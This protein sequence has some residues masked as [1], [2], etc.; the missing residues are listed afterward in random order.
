[1]IF[2]DLHPTRIH[3]TDGVIKWN[4]IG[5]PYNYKKLLKS[6]TFSGHLNYSAPEILES[7][8]E[9]YLS[10]KADVWALG[11]C[12]Y[13]VATKRDP[14]NIKEPKKNPTL[15]KDN[16]RNGVLDMPH[17]RNT[18]YEGKERHPI[19]QKLLKACLNID[20]MKR[21]SAAQVLDIIDDE[22]VA[23]YKMLNEIQQKK[24]AK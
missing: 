9:N 11:C 21:P 13:Y 7:G 20:M 17:Q 23:N 8:P 14:F 5:M 12:L 6:P 15:I 10:D 18:D 24:N 22:I 3:L 2:R 19:I 1:M 4:L 16:I